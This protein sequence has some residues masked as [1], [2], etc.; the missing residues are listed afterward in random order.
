MTA[1]AQSVPSFAPAGD[2][3]VSFDH[4]GT[5]ERDT[6][7]HRSALDDDVRDVDAQMWKTSPSSYCK[8]MVAS[9]SDGSLNSWSNNST[10]S[11]SEALHEG[12]V[13]I[14]DDLS[15]LPPSIG[16]GTALGCRQG[17]SF[18]DEMEQ[19]VGTALNS[20]SELHSQSLGTN[21]G[22]CSAR[23]RCDYIDLVCCN[24]VFLY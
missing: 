24:I 1:S 7:S 3:G 16:T 9:L 13:S 14:P 19:G 8:N 5:T 17:A 6:A 22:D 18:S 20:A 2:F 21:G 23:L 4:R 12:G 10:A 11:Q 15:L